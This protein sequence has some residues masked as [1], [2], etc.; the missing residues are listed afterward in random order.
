MLVGVY[1]TR[2]YIRQRGGNPPK[3]PREQVEL[4]SKATMTKITENSI[5]RSLPYCAGAHA[6]GRYLYVF[7]LMVIVKL[8]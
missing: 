3:T 6:V 7:S 8:A 2:D 1:M 5:N 4:N